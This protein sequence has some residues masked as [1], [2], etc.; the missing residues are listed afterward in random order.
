M[1]AIAAFWKMC[2]KRLVSKALVADMGFSDQFKTVSTPMERP[3]GHRTTRLG[4][5]MIA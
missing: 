5:D 1:L 2:C 3:S 4:A